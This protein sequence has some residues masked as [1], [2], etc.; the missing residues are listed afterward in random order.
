MSTVHIFVAE[1]IPALSDNTGQMH[2]RTKW[3]QGAN[4]AKCIL[5]FLLSGGGDREQSS[6]K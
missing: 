5:I 1:F 6:S 2:Q 3:A 4:V